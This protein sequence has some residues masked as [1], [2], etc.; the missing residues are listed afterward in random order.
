MAEEAG[1]DAGAAAAAVTDGTRARL[2]DVRR[3]LLRLHKLLLDGE[4]S[5]YERVYGP[6]AGGGALLQLVIQHPWFSW[7]R[8]VSELIVRID[9]MQDAVKASDKGAADAPP[10][11]EADAAALLA[12]VRDLLK[13]DEADPGFGGSYHRALQRDPNVIL[14]HAE[15]TR[16]LAPP[17]PEN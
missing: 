4:R 5:D 12:Q 16:L 15:I 1:R 14:T 8:M 10:V 2:E 11:S 9:E 13:P 7:L 3:G 6:V 17:K